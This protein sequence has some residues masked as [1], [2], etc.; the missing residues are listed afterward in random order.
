MF[1]VLSNT[2][3]SDS[4]S[5][6]VVLN[7]WRSVRI[8]SFSGYIRQGCPTIVED[9]ECSNMLPTSPTGRQGFFDR[10]GWW[11]LSFPKP[12]LADLR[13][14]F[15]PWLVGRVVPASGSRTNLKKSLIEEY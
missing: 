4:D 13:A 15:C 7:K 1:A 10:L 5:M 8:Q 6:C 2:V 14:R 3:I 9:L 11:E 12:A